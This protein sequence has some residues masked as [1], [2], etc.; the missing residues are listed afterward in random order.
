[1]V[2]VLEGQERLAEFLDRVDGAHPEQVLLERADEPLGAAVALRCPDEA[3]GAGRPQA[4][5]VLSSKE[6]LPFCI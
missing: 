3:R 6:P 5:R 4:T 1:M 2:D